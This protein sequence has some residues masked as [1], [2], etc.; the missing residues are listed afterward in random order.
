[1]IVV[2][3]VA[4]GCATATRSHT[5]R[6]GWSEAR[7]HA[8]ELA[9]RRSRRA[10]SALAASG[11]SDGGAPLASPPALL[12]AG[13][14]LAPPLPSSAADHPPDALTPGRQAVLLQRSRAPPRRAS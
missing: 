4:L 8:D 1:V 13:T 5:P 7:A 6:P 3:A 14:W 10:E 2:C 9:V 12:P 11:E